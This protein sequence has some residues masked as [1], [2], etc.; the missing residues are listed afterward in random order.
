[1]GGKGKMGL[2]TKEERMGGKE[3]RVNN[4]NSDKFTCI[5]EESEEGE[6]GKRGREEKVER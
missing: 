6:S 4:R 1:M 2:S 3:E 5:T